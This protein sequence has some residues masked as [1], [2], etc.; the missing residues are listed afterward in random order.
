MVL[1]DRSLTNEKDGLNNSLN[2]TNQDF[3]V[4]LVDEKKAVPSPYRAHFDFPT[5]LRPARQAVQ[6]QD[7]TSKIWPYSPTESQ[8]NVV[9]IN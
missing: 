7:T 2:L 9:F 3:Y 8:F 5:F 1:N 4:R 6:Q